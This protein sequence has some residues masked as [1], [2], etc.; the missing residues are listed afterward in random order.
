MALT[1]QDFTDLDAYRKHLIDDCDVTDPETLRRAI[2]RRAIERANPHLEDLD[3]RELEQFL[4][5]RELWRH[6]RNAD[7]NLNPDAKRD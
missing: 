2:V 4:R 5:T 3:K 7:F 6:D 1:A